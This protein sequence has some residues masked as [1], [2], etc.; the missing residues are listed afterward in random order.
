MKKV[1]R[2]PIGGAIGGLLKGVIK[3]ALP[4]AGGAL[5]TFVGGPLGTTIGSKL[6][7][8]AGSA[9]GLELEGLSHEDREFEAAK[10]FV[11]LAS[12]AVSKAVSTPPSAN[13]NTTAQAAVA[14]A[15]RRFTG[16]AARRSGGV[17]GA[18]G[19]RPRRSLVPA[20]PEHHHH[21]L[22]VA[23]LYQPPIANGAQG[24]HHHA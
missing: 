15:A 14:S 21:P 23:S 19:P 9:M 8:M 16:T 17:P 10:Q 6:A 18:N 3:K 1:V 11:R 22:L 4:I 13:P 7:S 5:G 20:V 12:D 2:S 24:G